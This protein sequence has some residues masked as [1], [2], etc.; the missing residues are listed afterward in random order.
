MPAP[1]STEP[2]TRVGGV[3]LTVAR[4]SSAVAETSVGVPGGDFCQLGAASVAALR[5]SRVRLD[6][7][8]SMA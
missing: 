7:S 2:P 1:A 8:A 6:P 4:P 3:K 5:V